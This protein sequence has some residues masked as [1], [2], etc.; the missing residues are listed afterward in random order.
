[1]IT[2]VLFRA[3]STTTSERGILEQLMVLPGHVKN[4][5]LISLASIDRTLRSQHQFSLK[6]GKPVLTG[7]PPSAF[8]SKLLQRQIPILCMSAS[9]QVHVRGFMCEPSFSLLSHEARTLEQNP[10]CWTVCCSL[11][12]QRFIFL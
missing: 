9:P 3:T 12:I 4:D 2:S 10:H 5:A 7:S 8:Y 1:M 6:N 11:F